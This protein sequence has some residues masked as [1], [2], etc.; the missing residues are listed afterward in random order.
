MK[1]KG[2]KFLFDQVE[3]AL[4]EKSNDDDDVE[5]EIKE[6]VTHNPKGQERKKPKTVIHKFRFM[7]DIP[8][9]ESSMDVKVNFLDYWEIDEQNEKPKHFSWITDIKVTKSN[10]YKLMRSGRA[11]WKIENETF[12]TLTNQEY[13]L[14]HN[15][16]LGGKNLSTN[17][18]LLMMIAFLVDQIQQL[19]CPLFQAALKKLGG[20]KYLWEKVRST[21]NNYILDSMGTLYKVIVYGVKIKPPDFLHR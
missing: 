14:K 16:G 17:F 5:F 15:F 20:K 18:I 19:C 11:R 10:S 21:F 3:R 7:N 8:L 6:L 13:N 2:N 12:N 4:E 9:N 1:P